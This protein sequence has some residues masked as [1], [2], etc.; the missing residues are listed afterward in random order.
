MVLYV[1]V[2]IGVVN[3]K[4]ITFKYLKYLIFYLSLFRVTIKHFKQVNN[5]P[6]P[7]NLFAGILSD[8]NTWINYVPAKNV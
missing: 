3:I 5:Y 7:L 1:A 2:G 6:C 4:T 8:G